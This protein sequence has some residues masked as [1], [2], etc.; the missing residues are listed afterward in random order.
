MS[1]IML[2]KSGLFSKYLRFAAIYWEYHYRNCIF[3][4]V[5]L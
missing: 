2:I 5:I 3:Q 1:Q 4:N